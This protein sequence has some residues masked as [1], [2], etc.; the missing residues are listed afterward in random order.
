MVRALGVAVRNTFLRPWWFSP[1]EPRPTPSRW[2]MSS[3]SE[4]INRK[5]K[6]LHLPEDE[7][8]LPESK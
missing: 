6:A 5:T 2:K 4:K 7:S 1:G 8:H 3:K